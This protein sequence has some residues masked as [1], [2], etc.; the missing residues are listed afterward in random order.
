MMR[1]FY[2]GVP[3]LLAL[4]IAQ[5]AVQ[6]LFPIWGIIPYWPVLAALAW[7]LV[8]SPEEGVA[9]AGVAGLWMGLFSAAPLG[10]AAVA[11]MLSALLV[12][13]IQHSL[14]ASKVI[15]PALLGGLGVYLYD[16]FHLALIWLVGYGVPTAADE[17]FIPRALLH[18]LLTV[19]AYWLAQTIWRKFEP[20]PVTM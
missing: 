20:L 16:W 5:A 4:T 15:L 2:L 11:L 7:G 10:S 6:P 9:W 1:S 18:A 12:T 19:P 14:P 8:H 17:T 13:L 3:L